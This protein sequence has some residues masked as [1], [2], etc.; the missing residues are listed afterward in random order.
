MEVE[1]TRISTRLMGSYNFANC[2]AAALM[3][4]YFEVPVEAI[5]EALESYTPSNNRSQLL[6]R[7]QLRIILDAYNA[8]PTSMS[9]ALEHFR[10]VAAPRKIALLGDM[11][12]LG[13]EALT[14]HLAIGHLAESLG[15]DHLYLVG[16]NFH[17]T[18]LPEARY[19][20]FEALKAALSE[21]PLEGPATVL[22]KGSRGMA[23][24]RVLDCF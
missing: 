4:H 12:E 1:G 6:V 13:P 3:G 7:G 5:R 11:F 14:E 23:L 10:Q 24:E 22:I 8:N 9:A 20:D 2:A 17:A 18:G 15:L 16:A 19:P 21:H